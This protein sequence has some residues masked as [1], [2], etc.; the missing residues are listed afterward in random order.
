MKKSL[1]FMGIFIYLLPLFSVKG[2]NN[3]ALQEKKVWNLLRDVKDYKA[4]RLK[5]VNENN[6]KI[7][8]PANDADFV[9]IIEVREDPRVPVIFGFS[10]P[11]PKLSKKDID[12]II[13]EMDFVWPSSQGAFQLTFGS[14][15]YIFNGTGVVIAYYGKP[16]ITVGSLGGEKTDYS[17]IPVMG[18]STHTLKITYKPDDGVIF[19]VLDKKTLSAEASNNPKL[20]RFLGKG[21][22]EI[23]IRRF[24]MTFSLKDKEADTE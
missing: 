3:E 15:S 16:G 21:F 17:S 20:L 23:E 12:N 6:G 19:A 14:N 10:F 7:V 8:I 24:K 2:G 9:K 18:T 4:N 1:L 13:V 11:M 22:E 5:L